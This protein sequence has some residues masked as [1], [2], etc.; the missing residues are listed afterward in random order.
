MAEFKGFSEKALTFL[1]ELKNNNEREWFN[2]RKDVYKEEIVTPAIAF[3][4]ELGNRLQSI[5]SQINYDT[6]TNGSGSLMRIYRDV[7]FSKDK[8]PYKTNVGIIFWQGA[9]KKTECPGYYFH[10]TANEVW[11][12]GGLHIFPKHLLEPYREAVADIKKANALRQAL[13]DVEGVGLKLSSESY[14]RV[15]RGYDNDHPQADL[16]KYKGL[17]TTK[18][19]PKTQV[20]SPSLVETCFEIC[21]QAAPLQQWFAKNLS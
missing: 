21:Q 20:S 3:I 12:G 10:M 4:E 2:E 6:R 19:I 1:R 5:S 9:G 8:K 18:D 16:L 14:K 13:S 7:R 11:I 15:P 17:Y